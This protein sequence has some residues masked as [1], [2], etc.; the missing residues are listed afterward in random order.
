MFAPPIPDPRAQLIITQAMHQ[1]SALVSTPW[2]PPPDSSFIPRT[3]SPRHQSRRA[4]SIFDTPNHSH[5][6][7][8]SYFPNFSLATP[9]E[10]SPELISSPEKL[11]SLGPRKSSMARAGSRTR[12]RQVSFKIDGGSDRVGSSSEPA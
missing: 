12:R 7:P 2:T 6:Y 4:D 10:S 8:Y 1:L 9:P 3:P 5:P 11:S